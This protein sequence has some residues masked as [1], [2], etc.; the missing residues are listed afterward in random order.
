MWSGTVQQ[1]FLVGNKNEKGIKELWAL[2]ALP[3]PMP[4]IVLEWFTFDVAFTLQ[5]LL[6]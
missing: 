1:L 6:R 5:Q 3:Q 2:P 4:G